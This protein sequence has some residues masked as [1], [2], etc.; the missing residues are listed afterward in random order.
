ML[1]SEI[2]KIMLDSEIITYSEIIMLDSEI[3]K[4]MLEIITYSEITKIMLQTKL[5]FNIA[6]C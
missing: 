1:D 3:S 4:I 6:L 5:A 2:S